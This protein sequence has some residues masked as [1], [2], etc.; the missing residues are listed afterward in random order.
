MLR[1]TASTALMAGTALTAIEWPDD[2]LSVFGTLHGALFALPDDLLLDYRERH[3][4]WHPFDVREDGSVELSPV[5]EALVVL[6]DLHLGRNHRPVAETVSRLLDATRAHATFAFRKAGEQALANVLYVAELGRQ[7]EATGG[8]SFRG[9]VEQLREDATSTKAEEAPVVEE[10]SDGVRVM[11]VHRAKGLEFPV[12]V[13][14][15][16]TAK[17]AGFASRYVDATQGLCALKLAGWSPWELEEH[18]E[19][20]SDRET[21]EAVRVAYVAATRARDVLVVPALADEPYREGWLGPLND[22]LYPPK[23]RRHDPLP[24]TACPTFGRDGVVDR[25]GPRPADSVTPGRYVLVDPRGGEAAPAYEVVWWDPATLQLRVPREHGVRGEDLVAKDAP[26]LVV[27]ESLEAYRAWVASRSAMLARGAVPARVVRTV[28]QRAADEVARGQEPG[29]HVSYVD[30]PRVAGPNG[31]R[32][33]EAG[34]ARF[35]ALVH[36][37]LASVPLIPA[38]TRLDELLAVQARVLGA[39]GDEVA[40]A[41]ATVAR[42]LA[43]PLMTRA[44][45]AEAAG[46]CR[47]ELPVMF[48]DAGDVCE[49]VVDLAFE[50]GERWIVVDFKTDRSPAAS[51]A[52]YA[53]Q[54][55][56]YAEAVARATGRMVEAYIVRV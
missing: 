13:L 19:V 18:R 27:Q 54:V 50:D 22:A 55:S 14:A 51:E 48:S 16:M 12:V 40:E 4:R 42:V 10:G 43:H 34:G 20:E 46:R 5:R 39:T 24:A 11:T 9:F 17:L 31:K 23:D 30:V 8:I 33:D 7:Y 28:R 21:S 44:A 2:E 6:R 32:R 38:P 56:L 36:A 15:D 25:D 29:R 47:R 26:P 41:G 37:V 52:L 3:R 49:G 45:R 35:G 1:C 53:H